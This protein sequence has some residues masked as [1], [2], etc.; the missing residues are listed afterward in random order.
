MIRK[1]KLEELE[2]YINEL[3]TINFINNGYSSNGFLKIEKHTCL[4]NNGK[5]IIRE[6][7]I[8]NGKDGSASA[9]LPVT[10]EGNVVLVVQPRVF[11]KL[12]VG[13]EFPA[14][15]IE[16]N[17]DPSVS[18]NRELEEETGYKASEI[19]LL[20]KYYQDEG[21]SS[22]FNYCYLAL[23]CKKVSEQH[24]DK[25]EYIRY[26]ECTFEEALELQELGYI[27]GVNSVIA[28]EKAKKYIR[29]MNNEK[30]S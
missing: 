28:L 29:G 12:I 11:S 3:K 30:N 14:G 23:G 25:D 15:Y 7:L 18:A 2:S 24:L 4:L 27:C 13:I 16:E 19:I 6:K 1:E 26:F 10:E 21:C 17:E 9:I 8:K 22:A 20:A 5:T